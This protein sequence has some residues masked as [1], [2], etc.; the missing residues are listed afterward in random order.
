MKELRVTGFAF[1]YNFA[2]L[3]LN[4]LIKYKHLH[5]Y[6]ILQQIAPVQRRALFKRLLH[7]AVWPG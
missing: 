5:L 1:R 6:E 3:S 2:T 4:T 7:S